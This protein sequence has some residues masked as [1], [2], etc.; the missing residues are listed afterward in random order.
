MTVVAH[1]CLELANRQAA[2]GVLKF[3]QNNPMQRYV[4]HRIFFLLWELFIVHLMPSWVATM[5][6]QVFGSRTVTPRSSR[7]A[8]SIQ[9][10][11]GL[12][13]VIQCLDASR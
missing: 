4:R 12:V 1:A 13:N 3:L 8:R 5:R 7:A 11:P 2:R 9:T 10:V 6:L